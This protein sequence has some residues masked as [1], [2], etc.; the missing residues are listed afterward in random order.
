V[1]APTTKTTQVVHL[2]LIVTNSAG[3]T[4]WQEL[5]VTISPK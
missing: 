2:R 5:T 1:T 4:N 3:L